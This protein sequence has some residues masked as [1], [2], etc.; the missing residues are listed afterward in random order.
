LLD[1]AGPLTLVILELRYDRQ[2]RIAFRQL[3]LL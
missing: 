3:E 1:G 2:V